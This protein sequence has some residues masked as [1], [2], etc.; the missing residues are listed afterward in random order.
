MRAMTPLELVITL[1]W[2]V[3]LVGMFFPAFTR[4]EPEWSDQRRQIAKSSRHIVTQLLKFQ[5][6]H[7]TEKTTLDAARAAGY[8][9]A[10]DIEFCSTSQAA[11]T[12]FDVRTPTN[13]VIFQ[14]PVIYRGELKSRVV[15]TMTGDSRYE[16]PETNQNNEASNHAMERTR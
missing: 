10:T 4:S 8:L 13:T 3:I 2:I 15:F 5:A 7:P 1:I 11:F 6:D 12:P 16:P 9:S 14:I